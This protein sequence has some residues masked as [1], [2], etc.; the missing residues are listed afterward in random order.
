MMT[1]QTQLNAAAL[2]SA[3]VQKQY[4]DFKEKEESLQNKVQAKSDMYLCYEQSKSV[5]NIMGF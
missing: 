5:L 2:G 1:I 4:E 3:D